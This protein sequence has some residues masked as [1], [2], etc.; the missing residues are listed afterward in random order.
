M[1]ETAKNPVRAVSKHEVLLEA[2][3]VE[4]DYYSVMRVDAGF[5]P[6]ALHKLFGWLGVMRDSP[7]LWE[8]RTVVK[9]VSLKVYD[10][11]ILAITGRSGAGKSTFLHLLGTFDT[12]T[13]G[14]VQFR[15]KAV[16][17]LSASEL[18]QFRNDSVGYVF[19]FYHL[20]KD[21]NA[22]ENVLLP[23]MVSADYRSRAK[24][25]K[26]RALDLLD[27]VGLSERLT[28][29]PNQLSGGEQQRV[30]IARALLLEPEVL[31]CD[32]P[33]GNLD[34]ETGE[35]ILDLLFTL[36]EKES[37]SYVIV[38]HDEEVA[39][40]ADRHIVMQDGEVISEKSCL[41]SNAPRP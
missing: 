38:T 1:S 20:F 34:K 4:K 22:V 36:R 17:K 25:Y 2:K 9:N 3:G 13:R 26:D 30:A 19:Q 32:E 7:K 21:L 40:R 27:Q 31:L 24:E 18:S 15:G 33:T 29:K 35:T 23:A 5:I 6:W 28:H 39:A 14:E 41:G 10:N 8:P 11:E 16:S 37:R 12:P